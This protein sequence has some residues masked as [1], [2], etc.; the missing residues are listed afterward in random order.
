MIQGFGEKLR[1]E[2]NGSFDLVLSLSVLEHVKRLRSFLKLSVEAA[3]VGGLI[4]HRYDLGHAYHSSPPERLKTWI[5][6]YLPQLFPASSFTFKPNLKVIRE[7]LKNAGAEVISV[8]CSQMNSLKKAM[9]HI[10]WKSAEGLQTA[11]EILKI[12]KTIAAHIL[13]SM[14][15]IAIES[16]FPTVTIVAK[17]LE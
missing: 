9:N 13:P 12:D 5:A 14:S 4:V 15:D 3:K 17:R 8:E 10:D 2:T 7:E 6:T 11:L 16:L 1:S